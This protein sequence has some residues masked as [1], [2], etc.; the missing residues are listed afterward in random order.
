MVL[1]MI[2]PTWFSCDL[3]GKAL[4]NII[5]VTVRSKLSPTVR[6][7]LGPEGV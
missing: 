5:K 1:I 4:A 6:V 3:L 7:S 2:C